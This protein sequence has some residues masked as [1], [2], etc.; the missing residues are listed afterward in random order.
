MLTGGA[1]NWR[2][3]S[4]LAYLLPE[5]RHLVLGSARYWTKLFA[6]IRL[7]GL[8]ASFHG[9]CLRW[10]GL[11]ICPSQRPGAPH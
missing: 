10:R 3:L 5:A 11:A 7:F 1:I 8:V 2:A 6:S 9:R 4:H